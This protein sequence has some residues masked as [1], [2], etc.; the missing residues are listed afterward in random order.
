MVKCTMT[1]DTKRRCG[2]LLLAEGRIDIIPYEG[3]GTKCTNDDDMVLFASSP[4]SFS[5]YLMKD[6]C[7]SARSGMNSS[8]DITPSE[9]R[10]GKQ[11]DR[12]DDLLRTGRALL[13]R[14]LV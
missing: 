12:G 5:V 6:V 14:H 7:L 11:R 3:L 8:L 13:C 2:V 1:D 10:R 9:E 4:S